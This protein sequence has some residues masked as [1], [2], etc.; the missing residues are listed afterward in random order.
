VS[1]E[2]QRCKFDFLYYWNQAQDNR[3]TRVALSFSAGHCPGI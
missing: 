3:S 1:T 2:F